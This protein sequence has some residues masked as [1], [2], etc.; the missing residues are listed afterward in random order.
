MQIAVVGKT[1]VGKSTF[2]KAA[3]LVDAEISNRI[4]TTIKPNQGV[5]YVKTPCVCKTLSVSCNPQ[6]SRCVSGFRI[7]PVKLLDIAGLVP[8]AHKGRGLGNQFLSD[9]ME[10]S[11][12]IHVVDI[13]GA[14]DESGN[15]VEPGSYN[16]EKDIEF[17]PKE[18]DFWL[19]GILQKNWS[20][21]IKK[22]E[23]TKEKLEELIYKQLSGLGVSPDAVSSAVKNLG[24]TVKSSDEELLNLVTEIRKLNKP[25]LI[26]ANKID[27]KAS[28]KNFERLKERYEIIPCSAESELALREAESHGFIE[29]LPGDEDFKIICET[30][31][32]QKKA[33]KFIRGV[34]EKYGSTGVQDVLNKTIF[35]LLKMIVVYPVA[36]ISK[37]TDKKNNV[38]PDAYLVRK[39]TTLKEFAGK[40]HKDLAENFIGGLNLKKQKI[41]A[42]Y[43]MENNDVVEILFRR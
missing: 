32:Q 24:I 19:L 5:G 30:N 41:G 17:L 38:L 11:A 40:I 8:D 18:I 13:S 39:G 43:I 27:V 36:N 4:F 22:A 25:I 31:E 42:N 28:E 20:Q 12:L 3:T 16:P 2:F 29:Y 6:N 21:I 7:I 9:I 1:N 23:T 35:E 37:L 26:A 14:T 15:P 10:A 34:L 33:L